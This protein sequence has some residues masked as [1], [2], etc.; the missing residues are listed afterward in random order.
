MVWDK[1][2]GA[3]PGIKEDPFYTHSVYLHI[4]LTGHFDSNLMVQCIDII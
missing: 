2:G 3:A 4:T 1:A